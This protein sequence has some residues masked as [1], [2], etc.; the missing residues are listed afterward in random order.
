MFGWAGADKIEREAG[1]PELQL[2]H[3]G[4]V[5]DMLLLLK[6]LRQTLDRRVLEKCRDMETRLHCLADF[7]DDAKRH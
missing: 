6:N 4:F 7:A 1:T 2:H 5:C 3:P